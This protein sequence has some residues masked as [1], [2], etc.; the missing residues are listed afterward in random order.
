MAIEVQEQG[1]SG[2]WIRIAVAQP[3]GN[4]S[5]SEI[6]ENAIWLSLG[7]ARALADKIVSEA[8]VAELHQKEF[9][10]MQKEIEAEEEAP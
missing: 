1:G 6:E 5:Y 3:E 7:E 2:I 4:L 8:A 9:E 10:R